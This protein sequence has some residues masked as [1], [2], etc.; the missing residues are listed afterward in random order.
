[1]YNSI[2]DIAFMLDVW[3][4]EIAKTVKE[5]HEELS[6]YLKEVNGV[7]SVQ[8]RGLG[9]IQKSLRSKAKD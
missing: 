6:P 8:D 3:E 5:L 2:V 9:I 1:M 4:T 7:T